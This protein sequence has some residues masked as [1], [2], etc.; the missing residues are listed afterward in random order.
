MN[1]KG[2][3]LVSTLAV[4][5]AAIAVGVLAYVYVTQ[6]RGFRT[7][8][9]FSNAKG[10]QVGS[11]VIYKG[12]KIGEVREIQIN[13][14]HRIIAVLKIDSDQKA[15]VRQK[16]LWVID[17]PPEHGGKDIIRLGY[18]KNATPEDLPTAV[19]GTEFNGEDSVLRFD[20]KT[21]L[22]CFDT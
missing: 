1:H 7:I 15:L 10:L 13:E 22:G 21:R 19:S 18:C 5:T 8:V 16:A 20:L 6:W 17:K 12:M 9:T 11:P 2:K 3:S 14:T 4:L